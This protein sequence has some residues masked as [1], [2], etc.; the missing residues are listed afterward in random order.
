VL[1]VPNPSTE[2]IWNAASVP[3]GIGIYFAMSD[4]QNRTG[5]ILLKVSNATGD[6]SC[7]NSSSPS[8]TLSSTSSTPTSPLFL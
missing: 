4:S 3:A 5:N 6:S 8:V 7:L 2:F 1:H